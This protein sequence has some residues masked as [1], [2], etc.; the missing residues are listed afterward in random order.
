MFWLG[1]GNN[2]PDGAAGIRPIG[3]K[4]A[5]TKKHNYLFTEGVGGLNRPS[6]ILMLNGSP[7]LLWDKGNWTV[8]QA[9]MG[10]KEHVRQWMDNLGAKNVTFL[11]DPP[12]MAQLEVEPPKRTA[13]ILDATRQEAFFSALDEITQATGYSTYREKREAFLALLDNEVG[14]S[15][16]DRTNLDEFLSWFDGS[17][18]AE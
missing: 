17:I 4:M 7:C 1:F 12:V 8:K 3:D 13:P 2:S 6:F 15:D 9:L 18:D 10:A 5:T 11:I 14:D 16:A